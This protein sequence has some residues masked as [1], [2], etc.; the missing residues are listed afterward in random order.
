MKGTARFEPRKIEEAQAEATIGVALIDTQVDERDDHLIRS[1][2][3][4]AEKYPGIF[5][6]SKG[7]RNVRAGGFDLVEDLTLRGVTREVVLRVDGPGSEIRD[8]RRVVRRDARA[9]VMVSRRAFGLVWKGGLERLTMVDDEIQ[10][11]AE[12]RSVKKERP[13]SGLPPG[14]T[15][16][17]SE[18]PHPSQRKRSFSMLKPG[19]MASMRPVSP[20]RGSSERRI[21]SRII[22]T[23]AEETLPHSRSTFWE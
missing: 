16:R 5:F 19:P 6:R 14:R 10:V 2:F 22:R 13:A 3:L 4:H 18:D 12:V 17:R 23:V 9:R 7:V 8:R 21:S 11:T 20:R 15:G 1:E